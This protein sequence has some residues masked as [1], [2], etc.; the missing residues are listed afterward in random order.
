MVYV[1]M[2]V[3]SKTTTF[4][5]HDPE[6]KGRRQYRTV[7]RLTTAEAIRSVLEAATA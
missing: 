7:T 2:D 1:G 5:L 6:A 3:H 4:C